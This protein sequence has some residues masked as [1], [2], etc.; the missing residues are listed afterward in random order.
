MRAP[1][2]LDQLRDQAVLLRRQGK[3]LRQIKAI[4]GPMSNTTLHDALRG[5]PPPEWT[6][7]PA[8]LARDH[9]GTARPVWPAHAEAAQPEDGA[10]VVGEDYHGC[11]RIDVRRGADLYHKIEGWAASSMGTSRVVDPEP[12]GER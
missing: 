11:L 4:L 6:R 10:A 9:R 8:V 1:K 2:E 7:R 5:E 12:T 3:S